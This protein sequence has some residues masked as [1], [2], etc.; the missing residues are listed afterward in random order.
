MKRSLHGNERDDR[1]ASADRPRLSNDY[2][3]KS[4]LVIAI[5]GGGIG[6][7][8]AALSLQQIG[9]QVK[10][11]ERDSSLTI[12]RQGYGLTLTNNPKGPLAKLGL[13]DECIAKDCPSNSHYIFDSHGSV[14][15]Y[16]GRAFLESDT[17]PTN[18][19][20]S[21]SSEEESF[22]SSRGNLRIPR[23]HLRQMILSRLTPGTVHW[24]WRFLHYEEN[25]D[26]VTIEFEVT[27]PSAGETKVLKT[28]HADILVGS[29]GIR[30]PVRRLR[31]FYL[32]P[33]SKR[34]SILT[35]RDDTAIGPCPLKYLG[36]SVILGLSTASHPLIQERGFY[37][38]DGVHRL[39]IMPFQV[40]NQQQQ[41]QQ[42][43][44]WQLSFSDLNEDQSK[45]LKSSSPEYLLT[46]ALHRTTTWFPAVKEIIRNTP[47]EEVWGTALFDRDPMPPRRRD[48]QSRVVVIGDACHPMSMFKG[49]GANQAVCDGPLLASWLNRGDKAVVSAEGLMTKLRC[50]EREMVDRTTAKVLASRQ[51]AQ[52]LH[53]LAVLQDQFAFEG[54]PKGI[55][56]KPLLEKMRSAGVDAS[57]GSD[58]DN[59]VAT[60]IKSTSI[61]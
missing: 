3:N 34:P 32:L 17:I 36:I 20:N 61:V 18:P 27:D 1:H 39:F 25:K 14:L 29:D 49:Q 23:E 11:F 41:K 9:L 48:Q 42:L 50:F 28:I 30:S 15:G 58:L 26:Q 19:N 16:Y 13:L 53:S 57:A 31:D 54:V 7:L 22:G 60:I 52:H 10:V 2:K 4:E 6:G 12:R 5:I 33:A 55:P 44:M 45:S 47:L 38:L 59:K 37:A 56:L 8:A 40:A 46:E 21:T 24:G 35:L 43:T 51:A